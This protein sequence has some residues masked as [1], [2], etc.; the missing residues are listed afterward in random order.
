M[1]TETVL[2]VAGFTFDNWEPTDRIDI[3]GDADGEVITGT[4]RFD[5]LFGNGGDDTLIGN[6]GVDQLFG[7]LG[8]DIYL[9]D[10]TSGEV[11]EAAGQGND[12]V[13][14]FLSHSLAAN[15]ENLTLLGTGHINGTG[16]NLNNVITGNNFNNTLSGGLGAD[17]LHRRARQRCLCARKRR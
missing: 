12:S 10:Q 6:G 3:V 15:V 16:N 13:L 9:V 4:V 17:T 8:N 5:R 7:G 1:G 14:A 11:V 2:D